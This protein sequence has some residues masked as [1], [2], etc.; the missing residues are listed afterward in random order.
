LKRSIVLLEVIISLVLFSIIAIVS[1]KLVYSLVHKNSTDTFT[2]QNNLI[3]ETTRLFLTKD[4]DFAQLRKIDSNLFYAN[5]ILLENI[6]N[7]KIS[8]TA[9][10][11]TIDICIYDNSICQVWKINK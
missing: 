1:S 6:S 9:H 3:L 11:T 2:V 5:N 8:K 7:Y 10:I 4:K